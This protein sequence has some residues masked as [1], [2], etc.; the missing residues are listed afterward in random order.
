MVA[1][2]ERD[3]WNGLLGVGTREGRGLRFGAAGVISSR[4]QRH[5]RAQV[6]LLPQ[7]AQRVRGEL[8]LVEG[9]RS[10]RWP[11]HRVAGR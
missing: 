4:S 3:R 2:G 10:L 1:E 8:L 5:E 11:R 6:P 7:A 9:K